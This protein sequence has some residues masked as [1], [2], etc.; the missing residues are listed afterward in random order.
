M[1]IRGLHTFVRTYG[2]PKKEALLFLHGFTGTHAT[3][4][5]VIKALEED[6]F[7]IATDHIG[8]G[9]TEV[10]AEIERF[11][12]EEQMKDIREILR[13]YRVEQVR[14]IG[15]SMGGR[16]ALSF[17]VKYP[18]LVKQLIVESS[19]PGLQT[20]E[21]RVSRRQS[22]E[23]LAARLERDGIEAFVNFWENIPLFHTQKKLPLAQREQIRSERLNQRVEGLANSLRGI[24]TGSQPSMWTALE[25]LSVPLT[26]IVGTLDEKYVNLAKEMQEKNK[27]IEIIEVP[28]T[29]HA[30]HVE[31]P[32][33]FATII[34]K[35]FS[36]LT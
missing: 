11:S 14:I 9:Q 4:N 29:G 34:E 16:I 24:G 26:C 1:N 6:Y 21:E 36:K 10:P 5:T 17:A 13:H 3:W 20:E 19:S 7:I 33:V 27:N 2:R 22:D 30:I 23:R 28:D 32:R 18:S 35:Q 31:K 8:H 12:M 25:S 15:Y